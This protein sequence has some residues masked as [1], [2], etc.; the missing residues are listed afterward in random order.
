MSTEVT[1]GCYTASAV[2]TA[3]VIDIN[4]FQSIL[5]IICMVITIL[6][7]A[8]PA[9]IKLIAKIKKYYADKKLS[10]E[11]LEDIAN[12]IK[13]ATDDIKNEINKK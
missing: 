12:D 9:V 11:E 13:S 10:P 8:V 2:S 3:V 7:I 5:S 4:G 1:V 6:G